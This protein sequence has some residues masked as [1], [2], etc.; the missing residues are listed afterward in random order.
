[1][2]SY[3][4][5]FVNGACDDCV[6]AIANDDYSGMDETQAAATRTGL[7]EIGRMLIVAEE[8]GFSHRPCVVC[9]GLAGNRHAV[10]YLV[11]P[12]RSGDQHRTKRHPLVVPG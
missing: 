10:G 7:Q 2:D 8:Q 11:R 12:E 3:Y 1:M 4:E 6:I 5:Q 9:G